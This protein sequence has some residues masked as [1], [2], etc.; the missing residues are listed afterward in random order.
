MLLLQRIGRL[1]Q[2]K[3][4]NLDELQVK[5]DEL[6]A[7]GV[8]AQLGHVNIHTEHLNPSFLIRKPSGGRRLVTSFGEVAQYSKPQPSLMPS[9]AMTVHYY[10]RPRSLLL[11]TVIS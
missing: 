11:D 8:V 7:A 5:F 2:Y 10:H 1:P 9:I 6:E 4:Y 3:K